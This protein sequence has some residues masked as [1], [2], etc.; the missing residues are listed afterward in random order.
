MGGERHDGSREHAVLVPLIGSGDE[1]RIV[2][3]RRP[4]RPEDHY[5]GHICFPGGAR[6]ASDAS[7]LD[8]A[9]REAREELGIDPARVEVFAELDWRRSSIHHRV[10]PFAGRIRGPW[11][12]DPS[13]DEVETVLYLPAA[14]VGEGLFE[15]RAWR[16]EDGRE[17]VTYRFDLDGFEVW[18]LTA[19]I[20]RDFCLE[21]PEFARAIRTG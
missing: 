6:E 18:G 3:I 17:L 11:A 20:L 14:R 16:A 1:S 4:E 2:L 15:T 10:K 21:S 7:L 5:S 8:C 9:L 19:R 13:P 12:V